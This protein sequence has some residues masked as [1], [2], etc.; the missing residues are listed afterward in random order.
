MQIN[1]KKIYGLACIC[2]ILLLLFAYYLEYW[3]G[4]VP[5]PL[6]LLQ[7]F[8]FYCLATLF[9][10][11]YFL[12]NKRYSPWIYAAM[13]ICVSTLGIVIAARQLY[14]QHLPAN[15]VQGCSADIS[16]LLQTFP[17]T[18][19]IKQVFAGSSECAISQWSWLGLDM[20][21]WALIWFV[22]FILIAVYTVIRQSKRS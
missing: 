21:G 11:A 1:N 13:I 19:V 8:C 9:F 16:Y 6:C 17:L 10:V 20:A 5:C 14:L 22:I 7:R 4:I 15:Q 12:P 3:H 18:Q 2:S